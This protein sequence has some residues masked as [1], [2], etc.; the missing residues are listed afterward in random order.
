MIRVK[1]PPGGSVT[2]R[3]LRTV[4]VTYTRNGSLT[5]L[6]LDRV[7]A[8]DREAAIQV[9]V[10]RVVAMASKDRAAYEVVQAWVTGDMEQFWEG[11]YRTFIGALVRRHGLPLHLIG[12]PGN[13]G[14]VK[15]VPDR[16]SAV[17]IVR[18]Y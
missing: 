1:L 5:T 16:A 6:V 9:G 10:D 14:R 4:Y 7:A 13:Y 15:A 3:V 17:A 12:E 2:V 18:P 11:F 8:D